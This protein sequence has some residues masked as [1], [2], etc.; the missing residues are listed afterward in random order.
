[1]VLCCPKGRV[2]RANAWVIPKVAFGSARIRKYCAGVMRAWSANTRKRADAPESG[3]FRWFLQVR[4][5]EKVR[6]F[7][8]LV[9]GLSATGQ[10]AGKR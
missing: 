2:I 5:N 9:C 1:M 7:D 6:W 4:G 10:L 8:A 3:G